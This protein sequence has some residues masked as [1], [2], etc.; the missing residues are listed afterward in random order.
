MPFL[1][2]INNNQ[3]GNHMSKTHNKDRNKTRQGTF[4]LFFML[5]GAI[6]GILIM[7]YIMGTDSEEKSRDEIIFSGVL[8]FVGM[9]AAIFLQIVI[10]EAGHLLFGIMTGYRFS[11]FRIGSFMWLKEGS[12]IKLRR[13]SIAGTGGQCLLIPPEMK[14]GKFSIVLYNLG[15][16]IINLVSALL[17]TGIAFWCRNIG[18]LFPLLMMLA[19]M[20]I[21]L[22]LMNGIPMRFGTV[23]NDGYNTFSLTNNKDALLS[24]WVQM[25]INGLSAAGARLKDM[26]DEWFELPSEESMENSINATRGVLVCS[27]LMDQMKFEEADQTIGKLLQMNTGLVGLHRNL[28]VVEQI[29]CELVRE[30]R[31]DRIEQLM[32]KQQRKFMKVMKKYPSVLRTEYTFALL[33][34]EE[35]TL[36]AQIKA[37]FEKIAKKYPY[38]SDINAEHEL[39][40][41]AEARKELS[42]N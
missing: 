9:Y 36:A 16:P 34:K 14:D 2:K 18:I 38:Q 11:S 4:I 33:S 40:A 25:K 3:K 37:T 42:P 39:I 35:D 13:L 19:L 12:T 32:D 27:R 24:F 23:N 22:S 41:Y 5:I 30:N 26:P 8:L 28:L 1:D 29:Y 6:C 15:G 7:N 21:A 17:F 20:G 10:H 31:S